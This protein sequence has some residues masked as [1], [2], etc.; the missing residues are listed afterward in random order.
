MYLHEEDVKALVLK[1]QADFP[2]SE[3]A[4]EV[5]NQK[6]VIKMRGSWYKW[7]FKKQLSLSENAVFTFGVFDGKHFES[8]NPGIEFL[9]EWTYFDE[10]ERKLYIPIK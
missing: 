1:L 10:Y 5:V 3:L 9:D 2:G 4:C 7:K 8:W 6:T